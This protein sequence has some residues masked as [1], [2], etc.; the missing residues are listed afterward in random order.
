MV[1]D[2]QM[3]QILV[4]GR[5]I[6][7]LEKIRRFDGTRDSG[8]FKR[9]GARS[10]WRCAWDPPKFLR[11]DSRFLELVK[12][13]GIE[14]AGEKIVDCCGHWISGRPVRSDRFA[15]GQEVSVT[16][17]F[18]L[19]SAI[20]G[21]CEWR[22]RFTGRISCGQVDGGPPVPLRPRARAFAGDRSENRSERSRDDGRGWF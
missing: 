2:C 10:R 22:K 1:V 20:I 7:E 18:K 8:A 11:H 4:A 21:D 9:R 12:P 3:G 19:F 5:V 17:R 14:L 16:S 13:T 6:H 15:M